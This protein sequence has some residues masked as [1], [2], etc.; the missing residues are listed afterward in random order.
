M[1]RIR[2]LV[3]TI[4]NGPRVSGR[5]SWYVYSR[6]ASGVAAE[7]FLNGSSSNYVEEMYDAW[8]DNPKSVHKVYYVLF[9]YLQFLHHDFYHSH[10][11]MFQ[12]PVFT[13]ALTMVSD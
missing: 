6:N 12:C 2:T 4:L 10:I 9:V 1:H 3:N 13:E 7:P 11:E 8:L 5:L